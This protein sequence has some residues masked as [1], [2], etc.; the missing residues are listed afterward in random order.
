LW[1]AGLVGAFVALALTIGPSWRPYTDAERR[2]AVD[3]PAEPLVATQ[4]GAPAVSATVGRDRSYVVMWLEVADPVA[5]VAAAKER[6]SGDAAVTEV[7][8]TPTERVLTYREESNGSF[9]VI[10]AVAAP[11]NRMYMVIAGAPEDEPDSHRFVS[12]FRLLP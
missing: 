12:S 7:A 8:S 2:F 6:M 11:P 1:F 9:V 4:A 10:R 3:M 5:E